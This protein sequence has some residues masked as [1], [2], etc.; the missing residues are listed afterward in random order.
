MTSYCAPGW[1][2]NLAQERKKEKNLCVSGCDFVCGYTP[3][4]LSFSYAA[5][6]VCVSSQEPVCCVDICASFP[7]AKKRINKK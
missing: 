6:K 1:S 7:G 2:G 4:I 3:V 5:A